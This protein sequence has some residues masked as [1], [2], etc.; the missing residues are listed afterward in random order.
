MIKMPD[1]MDMNEIFEIHKAADATDAK[2]N[3][4]V[5][6]TAEV[7]KKIQRIC[8]NMYGS[9]RFNLKPGRED[10]NINIEYS[11]ILTDPNK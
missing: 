9:I 5:F 7:G 3:T 4:F 1:E 10:V 8:P 11:K 6:D 2:L